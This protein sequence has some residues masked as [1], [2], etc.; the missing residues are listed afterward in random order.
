MKKTTLSSPR[1]LGIHEQYYRAKRLLQLAR[2]SKKPATQ[3]TNLIAA[4][5]PARSTVELMLEAA[6]KQ[7]LKSLKNKDVKESR[8]NLEKIIIQNIP[9]YF[10]LEKI[11]IHDFHRFGCLPPSKN[12]RVFYGGPAKL[13]AQQG[14]AG[15]SLTQNG[16]KITE[17]GNSAIEGQRPLYQ[18]QDK[19]FDE[20][21][22][23][24]VSLQKVLN[25]YLEVI[26]KVIAEFEALL[27]G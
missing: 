26:P 5:Y 18:R 11:R 17:T 19:F 4:V 3:F 21:S 1:L 23:E 15:I 24:F 8:K 10:L 2:R 7:E 20:E 22:G 25:D 14:V 12:H 9:F 6:E 16:L 13:I 27:K